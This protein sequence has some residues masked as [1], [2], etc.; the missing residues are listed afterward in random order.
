[1]KYMTRPNQGAGSAVMRT[2]YMQ[3]IR[4][5]IKYAAPCISTASNTCVE[6]SS[7]CV[8][9]HIYCVRRLLV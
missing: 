9:L 5:I 7:V 2:F 3:T 4:S 8:G 1:M 6:V